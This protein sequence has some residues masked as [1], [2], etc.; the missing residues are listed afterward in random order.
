MNETSA[1]CCTDQASQVFQADS[2]FGVECFRVNHAT[3][4]IVQMH[5]VI[6]NT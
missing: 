4:H 5:H 2:H 6:S 3:L 1:I